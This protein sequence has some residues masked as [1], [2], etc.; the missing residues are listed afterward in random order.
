MELWL[1]NTMEQRFPI[2]SIEPV[3]KGVRG[4]DCK[5][6]VNNA[7][8]QPCG[9][10]LWELK[11]TKNWSPDW[12]EK[13]KEDQR[14]TNASIAVLAT[15]ALPKE[16]EPFGWISLGFGNDRRIVKTAVR[17]WYENYPPQRP[18]EKQAA[19]A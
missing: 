17:V 6:I 18:V 19:G 16:I 5:Q 7:I 8:G 3:A 13:L 10:I 4:A 15:Q 14:N 1:E 11:R 12:I 2:D 9:S